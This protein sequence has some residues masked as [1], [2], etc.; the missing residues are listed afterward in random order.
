MAM[1]LI[2]QSAWFGGNG[3]QI[4]GECNCVNGLVWV[5]DDDNLMCRNGGFELGGWVIF[6]IVI[7]VFACL[8]L[9]CTRSAIDYSRS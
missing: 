5:W 1:F 4:I 7:G 8:V 6:G 3:G 2:F 9:S